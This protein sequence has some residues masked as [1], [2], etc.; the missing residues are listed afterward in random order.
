VDLSYALSRRKFLVATG[1]IGA[2]AA[3]GGAS[4]LL[5]GVA[6]PGTVTKSPTKSSSA[7][8]GSPLV[9]ISLYGGNDGLN[10][11]VPA[12]D[13][14]YQA[15]RPT[16]GYHPS[17][18]LELGDGL[19]LNPKLSGM[20]SLFRSGQLAIVRGVGYANPNLSHFESMD[21]WQS[22]NPVD[23]TGPGW[24]GRWLDL[25]GTDPL[26][27]I[28]VGTI[29]PPMLK[30]ETQFA[31]A[32]TAARIT[33]PGDG[34]FQEA[35]AA[36]AAAGP[37]RPG[38]LGEVA[39]SSSDLLD[40]KGRLDALAAAGSGA[41]P[42]GLKDLDG[43]LELVAALIN[44]GSPA[45][46]YQVSLSS[47]DTHADEKSN[48]ENL[49]AIL[50]QALVKFL[51]DISHSP[52]SGSDAV[53]MTFSEFG[54]RPAQNASGGT[55]HGAAAPLFVAGRKVA[56]GRFYGEEPS[57]TKLD[58][59]GNLLYNIDFR[60]VYATVLEGVLGFDSKDVLGASFPNLGFIRS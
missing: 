4:Y 49:L 23:G 41:S 31:T 37:D 43:A 22:A 45:R 47:F 26:R 11:V 24:L 51:S 34:P 53:V 57:L 33:L 48:H 35:F 52:G 8:S 58:P 40:A 44:A 56:G 42:L 6:T 14:A 3:A 27:A 29:L 7:G 30:G 1:V 5:A 21:I 12:A 36:M 16:L 18:V 32:L 25:T 50:D 19:G 54:R 10:T 46:V 2:A 38:L 20:Q 39:G 9:V 28:S 17:E 60:S 55:D 59:N 13:P 15:A